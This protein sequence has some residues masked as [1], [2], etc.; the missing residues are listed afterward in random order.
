MMSFKEGRGS[1]GAR[2]RESER[3][4]ERESERARERERV[5]GEGESDRENE[6]DGLGGEDVSGPGCQSPFGSKCHIA[7]LIPMASVSPKDV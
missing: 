3:A 6:R 7:L 5:R 1:E 4:R 2:E